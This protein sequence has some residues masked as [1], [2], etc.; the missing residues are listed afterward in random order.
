MT[1]G[2]NDIYQLRALATSTMPVFCTALRQLQPNR[3]WVRNKPPART[4]MAKTGTNARVKKVVTLTRLL[5]AQAV[6]TGLDWAYSTVL[7]L[8]ISANVQTLPGFHL[9]YLKNV[10][11]NN[12]KQCVVSL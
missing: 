1:K 5:A 7:G 6:F 4:R 11:E 10:T 3:S 8:I 2:H 12:A 9:R